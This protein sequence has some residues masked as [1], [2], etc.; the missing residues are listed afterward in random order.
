LRSDATALAGKVSSG[1]PMAMAI[2]IT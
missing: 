2:M 1:Q